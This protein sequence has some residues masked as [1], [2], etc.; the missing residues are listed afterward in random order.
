[1]SNKKLLSNPLIIT[2]FLTCISVFFF[3]ARQVPH[4]SSFKIAGLSN[5]FFYLT[6]GL[7]GSALLYFL[8]F[9]KRYS[10]QTTL[11]QV[12]LFFLTLL[13]ASLVLFYGVAFSKEFHFVFQLGSGLALIITGA[14]FYFRYF[15]K[16]PASIQSLS[17]RGWLK[18]QGATTLLA[19]LIITSTFFSFG[20]YRLG[21][22]AAVD[23]P[24]W[25]YGRIEKYWNNIGDHEWNKTDVSDKPGITVS[26]ISGA[27]LLQYDP[28]RYDD[29][30][31]KGEVFVNKSL[32]MVGFFRGFRLPILLVITLL[33]PLLYFL[34]ERLLGKEAALLPFALVGTAPLLIGVTKIINPDALLWMFTTLSL[35]S[36]FVFQRRQGYRYLFL[37]GVFLGLALLTKY[38]ANILFVYLLL[39]LFVEYIYHS[40]L[41]KQN[42]SHYLKGSLLEI[43]FIA[44]VSL[45][46][47]YLILPANWV[48]PRVLIESTLLSQAFVKVAPLFIALILL[49]LIDQGLNQIVRASCRERV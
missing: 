17:I 5:S 33:L 27:A 12:F 34:L 46:T 9:N 49:I 48:D 45:A 21:E 4:L 25:L 24:L 37:S 3:V 20:F 38:I 47:F 14:L 10:G 22:F 19:I 40:H 26:L 31:H 28:H 39:F 15:H 13:P 2:S 30:R 36:Y 42:F 29:V 32:D 35:L 44:F 6:F 16:H 1:M 23:E 11:N 7:V 41:K 43:S 18:A 8:F